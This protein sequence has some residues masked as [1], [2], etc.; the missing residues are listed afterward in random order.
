MSDDVLVKVDNVSKRFCR[1]LKRSL[2]YGLQD[3][4]SEIGGRRHGGGSGL[5]QSSDNVQLR[6][7][8]FW[9]VKDIS[10]ELRRGEC[11]G[12]IGH[13]GAG[14]STLL[15]LLNGLLKPDHGQIEMRGEVSALIALGA[16]FNPI[17]TG[18]ENTYIN[19][20]ILGFSKDEID[21]KIEDIIAFAD[22]GDFFDTPVQNYSSGM[23][24]RLGF[25]VA[26]SMKPDILIVDEVL[27]VGDLSFKRKAQA[28]IYEIMHNSAV[29]F[30]SHSMVQ[31]GKLCTRGIFMK[32]GK[33]SLASNQISNVVDAYFSSSSPRELC[34]VE[35]PG[36]VE[37]LRCKIISNSAE[38]IFCR[39]L[40]P[41]DDDRKINIISNQALNLEF[42]LLIDQSVSFYTV[43]INIEDAEMKGILQ[44]SSINTNVVFNSSD[45]QTQCVTLEIPCIPLNKGNYDVSVEIYECSGDGKQILKIL[46]AYKR[47]FFMH[48]ASGPLVYGGSP[49]QLLAGWRKKSIEPF[50]QESQSE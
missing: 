26:I 6:P 15:K 41:N 14:K 36:G 47:F 23:Q 34:E 3:L 1:S 50:D 43:T 24:V 7:D 29:I 8:E 19:A 31:V 25:S 33:I 40:K 2:W 35:G 46:R 17:L 11:L 42:S 38:E 9:A 12:L 16:G 13:N 10:F 32:N 37:M 18:R 27:A 20:S 44:S 21:S 45:G 4:G 28:A 39:T 49:V 5:P 30:V 22:I 48:V